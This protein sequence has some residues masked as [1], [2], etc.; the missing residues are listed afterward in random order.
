MGFPK[1]EWHRAVSRDQRLTDGAARVAID[2]STS[3]SPE[4]GTF[5]VRQQTVADRMGRS[6]RFVETS[7]A[8]LARCGYIE[9][10]EERKRGRGY[11]RAN[12]YRLA[13]PE[14][15]IPAPPCRNTRTKVSQIRL[16][17]ARMPFL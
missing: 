5:C 7:W 12:T 13:F 8:A 3:A 15:E 14:M 6:I 11:H 10:V 1:H 9:R 2:L 17:P 4:D 16:L